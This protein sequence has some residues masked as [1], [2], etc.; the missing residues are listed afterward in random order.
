MDIAAEIQRGRVSGAIDAATLSELPV[1]KVLPPES[2]SK[3]ACSARW[4]LYHRRETISTFEEELHCV[5]V[6]AAG[7]MLIST[8]HS[9]REFILFRLYREGMIDTHELRGGFVEMTRAQAGSDDTLVY[10]LPRGA[11]RT[12]VLAHAASAERLCDQNLER[13]NALA[14]LLVDFACDDALTRLAHTLGR[15]AGGSPDGVVHETHNE[16]AQMT[17]MSRTEVSTF[18]AR[19]RARGLL[20]HEPYTREIEV[21]NPQHLAQL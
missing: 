19:L 15:L 5:F 9:G 12:T 20:I 10:K 17:G 2:L 16:L 6:V 14:E 13:I 21:P 18:L 3:L 4:H 8:I 1:F 7:T 11:F